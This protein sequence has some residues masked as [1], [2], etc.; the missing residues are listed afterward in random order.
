MTPVKEGAV[1]KCAECNKDAKVE[2]AYTDDEDQPGLELNCG[3]HNAWCKVCEA[4]ARDV[5]DTAREVIAFCDRCMTDYDIDDEIFEM[6]ATAAKTNNKKQF[7]S[8]YFPARRQKARL[9]VEEKR[10]SYPRAYEAWSVDEEVALHFHGQNKTQAQLVLIFQRQPQVI[11]KRLSEGRM[12][13]PMPEHCAARLL[14]KNIVC[15]ECG[16]KVS[17]SYGLLGKMAYKTKKR[18]LETTEEDINI[19]LS[20]LRCIC[21]A[22]KARLSL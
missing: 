14:G 16:R 2:Y 9:T 15:G 11:S 1:V 4:P 20:K 7:R 13:L 10:K 22:N 19:S 5:S 12:I 18:V 3:C 6:T 17:L 21:G 8:N